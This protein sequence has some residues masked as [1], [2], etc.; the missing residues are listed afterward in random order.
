MNVGGR[1]R[2]CRVIDKLLLRIG[3]RKY[4]LFGPLIS[5]QPLPWL[6]LHEGRR[7]VGSQTRLKAIEESLRGGAFQPGVTLDIG[8]NLGYFSL[9]FAE[10]GALAYAVEGDDLHVRIA[11]I[12]ERNL[13]RSRGGA[14]VPIRMWCDAGSAGRLPESDVTLCLSIWHHW[15][16]HMGLEAATGILKCLI[17]K[18][19]HSLFFDTGEAEMPDYYGLPFRGADP[20]TWLLEYLGSF[21]GVRGVRALGQFPAFAPDSSEGVDTVS[22]HLFVLDTSGS[23][24]AGR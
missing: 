19:R 18:T 23:P 24:A 3:T 20:R 9:S 2:L 11:C 1:E 14:F 5:Y 10:G 21:P 13:D 12:A 16:R 22:R 15:V 7:S 8:A 17:S 4:G 6:G